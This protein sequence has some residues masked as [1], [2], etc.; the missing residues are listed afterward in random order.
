MTESNSH[1]KS[2]AWEES[3][4]FLDTV[5]Q[6]LEALLPRESPEKPCYI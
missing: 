2:R 1:S 3:S 4:H 6:R 5:F